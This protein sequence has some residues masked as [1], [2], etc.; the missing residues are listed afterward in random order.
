MTLSSSRIA[1]GTPDWIAGRLLQRAHTRDGLPEIAIGVTFLVIAGLMWLQVAFHPGSPA[2][3]AAVLALMVL[4]PALM[5][6]SQWAIKKVRRQF[7]IETVGYVQLKP[8]SQRRIGIVI[9]IA[10]VIAVAA[11]IAAYLGRGSFLPAA[12]FLAGTG[13]GGGALA[14]LSGR[15]PRYVIGGVVM[16]AMGIVL[17]FSKVSLEVGFTILYGLMGIL[18]LGSGVVVLLLLVCK[19]VEQGER[20]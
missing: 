19:P 15:S 5:L 18:A 2:H 7:L 12:W 11:V 1:E 10:V 6:G 14:A 20:K 4:V 8:A 13:I 3:R 17:A 16:A 9:G